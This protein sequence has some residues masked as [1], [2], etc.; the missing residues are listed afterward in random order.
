[1]PNNFLVLIIQG[2]IR[3]EIFTVKSHE[4]ICKFEKRKR[5]RKHIALNFYDYINGKKNKKIKIMHILK[6]EIN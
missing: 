2:G 3:V 4:K 6:K 1:M 5:N